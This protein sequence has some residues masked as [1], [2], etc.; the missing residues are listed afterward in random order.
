M[1][2][3]PRSEE[4]RI[5]LG[6]P[7]ERWRGT[8]Q[9]GR[10]RIANRTGR[11]RLVC[12]IARRYEGGSY[13]LDDRVLQG[14]A[15]WR[16]RRATMAIPARVPVSAAPARAECGRRERG[17][18]VR[19]LLRR[20]LPDPRAGPGR[21]DPTRPAL[22]RPGD[23]LQRPHG[24]EARQPEPP[25]K[26]TSSRRSSASPARS[27]AASSRAAS[28]LEILRDSHDI[29][30][31]YGATRGDV[32]FGSGWVAAEDRGLLLRLGLG[33]AFA[34]AVGV[35]GINAFQLLL[36][37]RSFTPSAQS[38]DVHLEQKKVA[39]RKRPRRR[40]GPLR[41]RRMG[42]R[43]QRVRADAA[44]SGTPAPRQRH[45]RDRGLRV[46]RL[47]LRQRRRR[48]SRQ[49]RPARGARRPN[50]AKPKG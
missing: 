15:T 35:P 41:P 8:A 28:G 43:H 12:C 23:A 19:R 6:S 14:R 10:R 22:E 32:M 37:Q 33:P 4:R 36:T 27:C 2:G 38:E 17:T 46:H 13:G 1:A 21:R 25:S 30:H 16:R 24:E 42:R 20:R 31:I 7:L 49:L 26:K 39:A 29:P 5:P 50:T 3:Q 48:R 18:D 44:G 34:A 40:T 9:A 47:D 45:R 11:M